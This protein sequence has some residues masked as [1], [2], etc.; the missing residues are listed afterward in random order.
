MQRQGGFSL[1]EMMIGAAIGLFITSAIMNF[2][3]TTLQTSKSLLESSKLN[4][5]LNMA[6]NLMITEIRRSGYW[7]FADGVNDLL[8]INDPDRQ[9][10][11]LAINNPFYLND[12]NINISSD[13]TCILFAYDLDENGITNK[14]DF[15]GFRLKNNQ[16]SMRLSVTS[17]EINDCNNGYW[18]SITDPY[19]IK[20]KALS[21]STAGSKCH[22]LDAEDNDGDGI[23]ATE[24]LFSEAPVN[25]RKSACALDNIFSDSL[26]DNDRLLEVR[27]INISLT[28]ELLSDSFSKKRLSSS[29]KVS[30]DL[31][32]VSPWL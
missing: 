5:E 13:G 7:G 24:V 27:Q 11:I 28:G 29:I 31:I 23:P 10:D 14:G 12:T 8:P 1:T 3:M 9:Q 17:G 20:I 4:Q 16:I 2:F 26:E 19:T 15:L 32:V 25:S 21:F 6:M 18:Q 30:N 22:N